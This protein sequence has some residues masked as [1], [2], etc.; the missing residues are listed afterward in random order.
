MINIKLDYFTLLSP[1]PIYINGVGSVKSPTLREISGLENKVNTYCFYINLFLLTIKEYYDGFEKENTIFSYYPKEL[2]N[3]MLSLKKQYDEIFQD[4]KDEI[5]FF[6][7]LIH[8]DILRFEILNALNFFIVED[9]RFDEKNLVYL[10][11]DKIKT[12]NPIGIIH[13]KNYSDVV[14]II[15]QR[16]NIENKKK[17]ENLPKVKN[18]IAEKLLAKMNKSE[19]HIKNKNDE[20]MSIAN[21]I[22]SLASHHPTLNI[23]NIWDIT[24]YQLYDQFSRTQLNDAYNLLSTRVSFWGDKENKFDDSLWLSLLN[25]K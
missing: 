2:K 6:N 25:K 11:Y 12:Q 16:V 15:L 17:D 24:I 22:S 1:D 10:I 4:S 20:K 19:L 13:S 14:D 8:D 23:T 3:K 9:V 7:Y 5:T 18:K 21:I